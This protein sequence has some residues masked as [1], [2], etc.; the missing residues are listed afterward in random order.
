MSANC[1]SLRKLLIELEIPLKDIPMILFICRFISDKAQSGSQYLTKKSRKSLSN[2]TKL[3][4]R[5]Q[6]A[7]NTSEEIT[8]PARENVQVQG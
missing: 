3:I 2:M 5:G 6:F 8:P 7:R 4:R 1:L